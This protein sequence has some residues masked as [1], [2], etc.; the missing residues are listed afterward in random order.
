MRDLLSH[1]ALLDVVVRVLVG[2]VRLAALAKVAEEAAHGHAGL[3]ELVEEAARLALHAQAP[4]PVEE[5]RLWGAPASAAAAVPWPVPAARAGVDR[6]RRMGPRRRGRV[7]AALEVE[8][9]AAVAIVHGE[10]LG[11]GNSR[12]GT[13]AGSCRMSRGLLPPPVA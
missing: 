12:G 2:A 7:E 11:F 6:G 1:I 3:V 8:A 5:R 4:H 9:E 13:R 10:V